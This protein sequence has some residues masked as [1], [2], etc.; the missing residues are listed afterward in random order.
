MIESNI[1]EWLE[2]GDSAQ[3]LDVYS[4]KNLLY[5]FKFLRNLIKTKDFPIIINL[6]FISL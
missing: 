1:I 6:I 2:F 4:K 5:L 3:I